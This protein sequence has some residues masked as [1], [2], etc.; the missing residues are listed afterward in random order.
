MNSKL[1]GI[2][3]N[4]KEYFIN[5]GQA[6]AGKAVKRWEVFYIGE[7]G[8]T[9]LTFSP[10]NFEVSDR[11]FLRAEQVP[12]LQKG[13]INDVYNKMKVDEEKRIAIYCKEIVDSRA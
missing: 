4:L 1:K 10:G 5:L 9:Q 11:L 13:S 6:I 3:I 12:G 8:V 2:L 7:L